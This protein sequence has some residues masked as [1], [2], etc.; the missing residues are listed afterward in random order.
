MEVFLG[1]DP[2]HGTTRPELMEAVHLEAPQMTRTVQGLEK[3]GLITALP[4]PNTAR[5]LKIFMTKAGVTLLDK[6]LN[7]VADC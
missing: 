2:K 7:K 5:S 6:L 1:I 4:D 3:M